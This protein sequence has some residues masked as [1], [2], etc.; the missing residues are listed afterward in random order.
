MMFRYSFNQS[1]RA[2]RIHRAVGA[3]LADGY[4][5]ADIFQPGMKRI[6]TEEMGDAVVAALRHE[7]I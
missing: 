6:G 1:D 2:D 3:V 7:E 4:R 5:T